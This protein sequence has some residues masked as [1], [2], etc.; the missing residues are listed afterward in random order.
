M[1]CL[2]GFSGFNAGGRGYSGA[3]EKWHSQSFEQSPLFKGLREKSYAIFWGSGYMCGSGAGGLRVPCSGGS[4]WTVTWAM[5][6]A[7]TVFR[8]GGRW[9]RF[10]FEHFLVACHHQLANAAL[11]LGIVE[12]IKVFIVADVHV[13]NFLIIKRLL[14]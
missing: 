2:S 4:V 13:V 12:E 9:R 14:R 10:A 11:R 8:R 6:C 7:C 3:P 5:P 1:G